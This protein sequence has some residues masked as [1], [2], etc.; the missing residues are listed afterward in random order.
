MPLTILAPLIDTAAV[1]TELVK[2]AALLAAGTVLGITT[3]WFKGYRKSL[4]VQQ[5]LLKEVQDSRGD[6]AEFKSTVNTQIGE[7]KQNVEHRF[8]EL[9]QS[10]KE[11]DESLHRFKGDTQTILN[12]QAVQIG[13]MQERLRMLLVIQFGSKR[14]EEL[15]ALLPSDDTRASEVER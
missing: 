7:L 9:E 4:A 2:W 3:D 1:L 13:R 10:L 12:R 6:M 11:R 5:Q 14:A 15:E 8:E